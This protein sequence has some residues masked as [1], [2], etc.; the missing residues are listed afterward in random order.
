MTS[1]VEGKVALLV[2]TTRTPEPLGAHPHGCRRRGLWGTSATHGP[3]G[4]GCG[5][6]PSSRLTGYPAHGGA[7]PHGAL[8]AALKAR[9]MAIW[10][11]SRC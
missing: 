8:P 3:L 10:G 11:W 9:N 6:A 1:L 4:W 2:G 7:T 5:G